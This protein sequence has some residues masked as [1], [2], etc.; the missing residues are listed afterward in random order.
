MLTPVILGTSSARILALG[1]TPLGK[2]TLR[3]TGQHFQLG[4]ERQMLA[5]QACQRL[6]KLGQRVTADPIYRVR[7]FSLGKTL[8]LQVDRGD[9]SQV[10]GCKAHPEWKL[11]AEALA[12]SCAL[13]CAD[14]F[15]IER[16][17]ARVATVPNKWHVAPSGS[18]QPPRCA[19][20]TVFCEAK[21]ELGLEASEL[22]E[23]RCTGLIYAEEAGVY[24]LACSARTSLSLKALTARSRSGA[25]E[26]DGLL[27]APVCPEAL[28]DWIAE[29]RDRLVPAGVA[30]LWTEGRR[31]WGASWFAANPLLG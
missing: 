27:T 9:Y 12:V 30:V 20:E 1:E 21:E 10:V 11:K 19:L 8:E 17:S 18:V 16:R 23:P 5:D 2:V 6:R 15:V 3:E 28:P 22:E 24:L 13:E 7:S 31:R 14:G 25:W 26:Q 29:Q 4:P